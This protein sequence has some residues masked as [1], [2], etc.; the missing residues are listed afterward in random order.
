MNQISKKNWSN[1]KSLNP[2]LKSG[3]HFNSMNLDCNHVNLVVLTC[4]YYN[5]KKKIIY[6]LAKNHDHLGGREYTV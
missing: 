4:K 5:N 3:N 2:I 1:F 6:N